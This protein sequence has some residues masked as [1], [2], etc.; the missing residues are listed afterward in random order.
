[1]FIFTKYQFFLIGLVLGVF[2]SL[3][4][5]PYNIRY[6]EMAHTE[7]TVFLTGLLFATGPILTIAMPFLAGVTSHLFGFAAVFF[8]LP[9]FREAIQSP[10]QLKFQATVLLFLTLL[11][12]GTL[13][14]GFFST[15]YS[16]SFPASIVQKDKIPSGT[17]RWILRLKN[18]LVVFQFAVSIILI[19]G[20]ITIFRQINYMMEHDL[21]FT[22]EGLVVLEGPRILQANSYESYMLNL[23]AFKDDI[24]TLAG[25][26][27]VT[28]SSNIP[29]REIKQSRVF[30]IPVEGRNTEKKIE[31]YY[32]T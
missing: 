7:N 11:T 26:S 3:F 6:F 16:T 23:N 27:N 1:M 18:A 8:L 31:M 28:A 21:G 17:G 29:G 12:A 20:T 10:L 2:M 25:V 19:I 9:I 32:G 15:L 5:I 4:W 24:S 14:T 22:P 13:F 30:G